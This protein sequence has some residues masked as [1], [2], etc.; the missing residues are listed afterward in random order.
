[1][2]TCARVCDEPA[3]THTGLNKLNARKDHRERGYFVWAS[4]IDSAFGAFVFSSM[5]ARCVPSV[6]YVWRTT[7]PFCVPARV[8]EFLGL[9]DSDTANSM[10]SVGFRDYAS[11]RKR[12]FFH[13][14][15]RNNHNNTT[16]YW[17]R[18]LQRNLRRAQ[19]LPNVMILIGWLTIS[20]I[21]S[22]VSVR[23]GKWQQ[24]NT[25]NKRA[26][27]IVLRTKHKAQTHWDEGVRNR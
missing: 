5:C 14:M 21:M 22:N 26:E 20:L 4:R 23:T 2:F 9:S 24:T 16:E 8:K 11:S 1:M 17:P 18:Q 6:K 10:S 3:D 13:C 12:Y 27:K 7:P 19:Y 25:T 15:C